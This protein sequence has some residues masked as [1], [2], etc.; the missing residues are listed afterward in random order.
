MKRLALN[1]LALFT[2]ALSPTQDAL[3]VEGQP[4]IDRR[5][6]NRP[7][8]LQRFVL[9]TDK[10]ASWRRVATKRNAER[11]VDRWGY[12]GGLNWEAVFNPLY[13]I[14]TPDSLP[15]HPLSVVAIEFDHEGRVV[16][17]SEEVRPL[18][19]RLTQMD[20]LVLSTGDTKQD[21]QYHLANWFLGLGDISTHWAPAF[22]FI[23]Q[24]SNGVGIKDEYY[25]YGKDF[26]AD[27]QSVTF[28]CREWVF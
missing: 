7:W 26:K 20:T 15:G 5:W 11:K 16:T 13:S 24:V 8:E 25:I 10:W 18:R 6:V 4:T 12:P 28:G 19:G 27:S 22:C 14:Q 17:P 1:L 9:V 3:A 23:Q 21:D 2:V